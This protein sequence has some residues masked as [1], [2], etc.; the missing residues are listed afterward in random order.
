MFRIV[1]GVL[2]LLLALPGARAAD[3]PKDKPDKPEEQYKALLKEYNDAFQEYVK[4]VQK[5]KTPEDQ[6]K[7]VQEKYPR[8][9][10]FAP[11]FLELAEKNPKAPFAEDALIWVVANGGRMATPGGKTEKDAHGKALEILLRDHIASQKMSNVVRMLGYSRDKDSTKL[12][13][14][15]LDK[16]PSKE[17]KAEACMALAREMQGR[18][19]AA[20]QLKDNPQ[21]AKS[22]EQSYGKAYLEELRKADPAK[23]EAESEKLYAELTDKYVPD[24]KPASVVNLCQQLMYSSDR[25]SEK[26]LRALY[27]KDKRKEVRGVACLIL[28]QAL[29]RNADRL[30]ASDA[31]AAAKVQKESEKLLEEAVDKYADVNLSFYGTVGKKA[32]SELFDLHNLSVGKMAPEVKGVDQDGKHFKLADYKGKVVLLDFWSQN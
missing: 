22:Y 24:M 7:A 5:A 17:V 27:E 18:V 12:L 20:R 14:A 25:A 9:D 11:K 28:A 21:L 26:L 30:A 4:A 3:D 6:Q 31:R 2:L 1:G 10:K 32:K 13:R 19:V 15:I 29:K 16:S 23:L 8:P